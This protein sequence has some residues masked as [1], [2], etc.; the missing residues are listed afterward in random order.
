HFP[1]KALFGSEGHTVIANVVFGTINSNETV[2][3]SSW[4]EKIYP[5]E[6]G[7]PPF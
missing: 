1:R 5:L 3:A 7:F 2:Y 6:I 4:P